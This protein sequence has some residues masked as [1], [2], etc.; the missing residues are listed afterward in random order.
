M[1]PQGNQC[2]AVLEDNNQTETSWSPSFSIGVSLPFVCIIIILMF[3]L[4]HPIAGFSKREEEV[5]QT[6]STERRRESAQSETYL[7]SD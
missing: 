2:N 6:L 7:K 4:M 3:H 5:L 1:N